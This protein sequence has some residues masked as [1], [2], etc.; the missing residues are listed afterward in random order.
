MAG[1]GTRSFTYA[2]DG[3]NGPATS[4]SISPSG[5]AVDASGNLYVTDLGT[6]NV[7]R[8][9]NGVITTI[10]GINEAGFYGDGGPATN[11]MLNTPDGVAIDSAGNL[12]I[13]DRENNRIRKISNG[14]ITTV[15]GNGVEGFSGDGGLATN[16]MLNYPDGVAVDSAG[17]L[18]ISDYCRIRKVSNGIITTVAGNGTEGFSG[19]NGPAA[20]ATIDNIAGGIALDAAGNLY[21]TDHYNNRIRMISNGVITTIAGG[22]TRGFADNGPATEAELNHPGDVAVDSAGKVYVYDSLNNRVRLL[23]TSIRPAITPG[24]IVPVYST[25]S[26]IQPGSWVSIYGSNLANG[27]YLWNNDFPQSL[28]GTTVTID[29]RAA[30]LWV[31]SPTQINLQV[32]DDA[33]TGLVS[34]V[35]DT[36]SGT[37][38]TTVTLS[39]FGPSFSVLGDGKHVA[40]E[41]LTT[42]GYD[43]VGPSNT[44]S[45]ATRPVN[46][47]ETLVI[48]G[49]GFGPT[50]PLVPAGQVFS[51]SAPTTNKV[52]ITIGGVTAN[53]SY[54]GITE[55]G[56]YQFNL[57]VPN[58]PSGDQALQATVNGVQTPLGPLVTMQ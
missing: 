36:P 14:V 58:A 39:A 3:D 38:T 8:I 15:A 16:A 55:E 6:N 33:T 42:N 26:T 5:V 23:S 17:N 53:V 28:G 47:G 22:G 30:Y 56:L 27:T 20:S 46:P 49:V 29:G 19:D 1:N 34:V 13:A 7:R 2:A 24:G 18:Y 9:S 52:T 48:Y 43:L 45:F 11:A 57:T 32:P 40:G 54:S 44:F 25:V 4:A 31:V 37:A 21:I 41:I 12:Y 35:V 10:A 51:S 50:T